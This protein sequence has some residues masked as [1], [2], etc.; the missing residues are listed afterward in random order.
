MDAVINRRLAEVAIKR[1]GANWAASVKSGEI[2]Y[3]AT[4]S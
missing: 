4:R 1:T 3:L 2:A